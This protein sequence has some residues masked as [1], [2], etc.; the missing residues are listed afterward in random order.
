VAGDN[1]VHTF[2]NGVTLVTAG[3]R[4]VS[5]TDTAHSGITGTSANIVVSAGSATTVTIVSGSGQAAAVG[6]GFAN[7]LVA[8]LKDSFGNP[9]PGATV[10]FTA[11]GSGASGTFA[12]TTATTTAVTNASG[13]ATSSAFTANGTPGTYNVSAAAGTGSVNF[14][15]T[16][17]GG[18]TITVTGTSGSTNTSTS[19]SGS[20]GTT[21]AHGSV[22]FTQSTGSPTINVN[23]SGAVTTSAPLAAGTYTATGSVSDTSADTGTWTFTLNVTGGTITVSGTSGSTPAGTAFS[24]SMAASGTH[25][26]VT[27]TQ[28]TGTPN[29]TVSSSGAV[30]APATLTPN[31]Y[32]A[33]GTVSD[34]FGDTGSW[35]FTLTVTGTTVSTHTTLTLNHDNAEYGNESHIAFSVHV[36]AS[37]GT[38]TGTVSI[39]SSAGTLCTVTLSGGVG[40]CSLTNTQLSAGS[41][42]HVVAQYNPTA[43]FGGSS[44]TTSQT[45]TIKQDSTTTKVSETPTSVAFGSESTSVF[46]VTVTTGNGE[47]LPA[48]EP[49]TVTVGSTSCV[50]SV[51][52]SGDGGTGTCNIGNSALAVGGPYKVKASY[53]GDVDLTSSSGTASTGLTVTSAKINQSPLSITS[54]NGTFGTPLTLT[55]SGGSGTG[56]VSF[57]VNGGGT[58]SGCSISS[59][60]LSSTSAGTCIVT[61]T[62]AGD[63]TYNPISSSPT[64]IT[65]GKAN[66]AALTV[67]ST[68]GTVGTPLT[69]TTSG[70]SGTGALSFVLNSGGTASGCSLSSGKLS[71]T[72]A[73]TCIVTATKAGDSNYNQVSSAATAITFKANQAALSITSTNGTFGTPLTLTTS[74]GSG[75][76]AVSFVVDSGG[77]ASGCSISSGQLSATSAGTCIVTATKAGDSNFNQVSSSPT[78]I[79]LGKANQAALSITS[80]NGTLGTPLTLTTSGGSGT[81]AV[82]F[83]VNGGGTASGC[84]ISSG[85]L[86]STSAGTCIVTATKAGDSN[87]NQVSSAATAITIA[88]AVS[89]PT[90]TSLSLSTFL[91]VFGN[92]SAETFTVHVTASSGT[93]TGTVTITSSAGT[94]CTATLSAGSGTCSLTNT[95]LPVGFYNNIVAVYNPTGSF[96]ASNS[97]TPQTIFVRS[98]H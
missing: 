17:T 87:Y 11:P 70:G 47:P 90:H 36:T 63:S 26:T 86:S 62:K 95:Q 28:S 27:F 21:G 54:T 43:G 10:T 33:T 29:I 69:L 23:S 85:K 71:A 48:T 50:A 16:N 93:P 68:S 25:G 19:F 1:G 52:P 13:D 6:T 20:M 58:A 5:A 14:S 41:Y 61:A 60:Q 72:S 8:L 24:G 77:T 46:T 64:T 97:S 51:A 74:G 30:T 98:S 82:S 9:V 67:T 91:P 96:Q 45:F 83:V 73:G 89:I 3:S 42:N 40:T 88:P 78:T 38:P 66:Q 2:T 55:T 53:S 76:G 57:A 7:P 94:L 32:T 75:T 34:T 65:L 84:S 4:T 12:N 22:T 15:E 81:G 35:T 80:T 31:T 37:S 49:V 44:S 39:L 56:A 59:G 92:E 79:T 18:G